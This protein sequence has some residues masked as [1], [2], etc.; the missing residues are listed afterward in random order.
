MVF[1][2]K[3]SSRKGRVSFLFLCLHIDEKKRDRRMIDNSAYPSARRW[4]WRR[5]WSENV[6]EGIDGV[7]ER[8]EAEAEEVYFQPKPCSRILE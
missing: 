4:G 5:W 6:S 8:T 1:E 7:S 2:S 3:A